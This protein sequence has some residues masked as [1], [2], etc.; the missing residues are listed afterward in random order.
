MLPQY[1]CE[2]TDA[3]TEESSP[4]EA[5]ASGT[6]GPK[7]STAAGARGAS[8][9]ASPAAPNGR[10]PPA[11]IQKVI[12]ASYAKM[13]ACYEEGLKRTENLGGKVTTRFVIARD[14]SVTSH[15]MVCT[16]LPDPTVVNCVGQQ[17]RTLRFPK[18]EAGVVTV[19]YPITFE[20]GD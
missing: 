7:R 8:Q 19:A 20:P 15:T 5:A 6:G 9:A 1:P 16:S 18:P 3:P 11:I 2:G 4:T 17:F 12:R 13:R 14:G 10:L